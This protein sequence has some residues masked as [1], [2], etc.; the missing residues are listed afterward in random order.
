[1][2]I[3]A[4][5]CSITRSVLPRVPQNNHRSIHNMFWVF[6]PIC[7]FIAWQYLPTSFLYDLASPAQWIFYEPGNVGFCVEDWNINMAFCALSFSSCSD[8]KASRRRSRLDKLPLEQRSSRLCFCRK[9]PISQQQVFFSNTRC[10]IYHLH[11]HMAGW[12]R[13]RRKKNRKLGDYFSLWNWFCRG[14]RIAYFHPVSLGRIAHAA[15][16]S[17]DPPPLSE[18]AWSHISSPLCVC[19]SVVPTASPELRCEA[20]DEEGSLWVADKALRF[21]PGRRGSPDTA[22]YQAG[23]QSCC[24]QTHTEQGAEVLW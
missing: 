11:N 6:L 2:P 9:K 13:R 16:S 14:C 4:P 8:T 12:R 21:Q 5:T 17:L 19:T 10:T 3:R 23:W 1:M 24:L 7:C 20:I 15:V 18:L 22:A